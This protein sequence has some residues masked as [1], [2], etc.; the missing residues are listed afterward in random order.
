MT[1]TG[2][3]DQQGVMN[4]RE[5]QPVTRGARR[6]G[7]VSYTP[8]LDWVGIKTGDFQ[9]VRSGFKHEADAVLWVLGY[10]PHP[11]VEL[12]GGGA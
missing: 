4:G 5:H 9:T 3:P 8:G 11:Q 7:T 6:Y 12:A 1:G 10:P 2:R